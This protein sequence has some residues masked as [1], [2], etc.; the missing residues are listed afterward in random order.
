MGSADAN[1]WRRESKRKVN[2][3]AGGFDTPWSVGALG[4]VHQIAADDI[5]K[6]Q[7]GLRK[8]FLEFLSY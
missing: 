1:N 8:L 5:V 6:H 4:S 3:I 7:F 2:R